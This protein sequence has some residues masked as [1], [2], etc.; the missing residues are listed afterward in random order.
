MTIYNAVLT[1]QRVL[2]VGYNHAAGDVCKIVLAACALVS[3]PLEVSHR[4]SH[5]EVAVDF[6]HR[7]WYMLLKVGGFSV[8][9]KYSFASMWPHLS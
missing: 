7:L 3:P 8:R 1:G 6:N 2:F 9:N 5:H 4:Q